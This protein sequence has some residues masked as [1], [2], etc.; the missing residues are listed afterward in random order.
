MNKE[1]EEFFDDVDSSSAQD[2]ID[3]M[4]FMGGRLSLEGKLIHGVAP[5]EEERAQALSERDD[6]LAKLNEEI[7]QEIGELEESI[8]RFH[9]FD[10]LARISFRNSQVDPETY[11]EYEF[12]GK[13]AYTEYL[14]CLYLAKSVENVSFRYRKSLY[15]TSSK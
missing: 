4:S 13:I 12:D 14:A 3:E 8:T 6:R 2:A 10:L 9:P 7:E 5:N 11:K 1:E 15:R